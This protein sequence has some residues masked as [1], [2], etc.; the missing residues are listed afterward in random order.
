M[1]RPLFLRGASRPQGKLPAQR[2]RIGGALAGTIGP[3]V[4]PAVKAVGFAEGN[5]NI[6]HASAFARSVKQTFQRGEGLAAVQH[7]SACAGMYGNLAVKGGCQRVDAF[8]GKIAR[9]VSAGT[10]PGVSGGMPRMVALPAVGD[11]AGN[12]VR[13]HALRNVPRAGH[14][15]GAVFSPAVVLQAH[16]FS[17]SGSW[18]E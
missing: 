7:F 12:P 11:L 1:Y 9:H 13:M 10:L 5:M 15:H 6:G 8:P 18:P 14:G 16:I 2:V 4:E 17:L 3:V